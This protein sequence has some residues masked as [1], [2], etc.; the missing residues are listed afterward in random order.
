VKPFRFRLDR[1][2]RVRSSQ[3]RTARASFASALGALTHAESS[4]R[5]SLRKRDTARDELRHILS[6]GDSATTFITAQR[7]TD[8]FDTIVDAAEE[9]RSRAASKVDRA[10][11]TW[12]ALRAKH[13]GLSRLR[14]SRESEHRREVER[15]LAR[16]LDEFAMTRA[17]GSGNHVGNNPTQTKPSS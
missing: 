11:A 6:I 3:E 1:L 14:A 5:D 8:R 16:E 4:L 12:V 15:S 17:A 7:V 9:D 10:R 2:K 13:E